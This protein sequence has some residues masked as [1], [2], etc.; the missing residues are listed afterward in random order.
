MLA[1]EA[2]LGEGIW[3]AASSSSVCI[4]GALDAAVSPL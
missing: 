4:S 2:S 3:V 1:A